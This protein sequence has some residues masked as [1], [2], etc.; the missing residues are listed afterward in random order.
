MKGTEALAQT[1]GQPRA[2]AETGPFQ[3]L[4]PQWKEAQG[5]WESKGHAL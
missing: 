3:K 2:S 1:S 4:S 5:T